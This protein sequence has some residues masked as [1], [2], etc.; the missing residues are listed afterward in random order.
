MVEQI[1]HAWV[2][3]SKEGQLIISLDYC[4]GDERYTRIAL[5]R[6][7]KYTMGWTVE[8]FEHRAAEMEESYGEGKALYDPSKFEEALH[9]MVNNHD[10]SMG[11]SW[12]SVDFW[13]DEMCRIKEAQ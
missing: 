5:E 1:T 7:I 8:D 6:T 13:L 2:R 12:E 11:I 9:C 10:A 3:F 4:G